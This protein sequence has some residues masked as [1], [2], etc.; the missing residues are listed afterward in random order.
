MDMVTV[1]QLVEKSWEHKEKLFI[2]K[3]FVDLKK[4]YDSVPIGRHCRGFRGS[5]G[6]QV[7]W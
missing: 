6:F 4:V 1:R 7:R 2:T 3:S 5:L